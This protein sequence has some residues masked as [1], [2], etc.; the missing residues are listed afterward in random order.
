MVKN[1]EGM[2]PYVMPYVERLGYDKFVVYD[3]SSTDNTVAELS[4]YPFVEIRTITPSSNMYE[5]DIKKRDCEAKF[6][7]ECWDY[8]NSHNGETVW[9]AFT[10]FDEV[11]FCNGRNGLKWEIENIEYIQN[12]VCYFNKPLVQLVNSKYIIETE[13]EGLLHTYPNILC[14]TWTLPFSQK[15]TLLKVNSIDDVWFYGGNHQIKIKLN[16]EYEKL[17]ESGYDISLNTIGSIHQFHLKYVDLQI[18]YD[19][20]KKTLNKDF[21]DIKLTYENMLASSYPI[22][23]YFANDALYC[24][25]KNKGGNITFL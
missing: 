14:S 22:S 4:K 1:E 6:Y 21:S 8:I 20:I 11:L 13:G 12:K 17:R 15:N 16:S 10:D 7:G 5:V 25:L 3:D 23:Q 2:I 19:K 18:V 9:M 24:S